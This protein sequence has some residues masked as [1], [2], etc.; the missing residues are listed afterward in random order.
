M[1]TR[2]PPPK[3]N[4]NP[5]WLPGSREFARAKKT[6]G[7]NPASPPGEGGT[8]KEGRTNSTVHSL[9]RDLGK[10]AEGREEVDKLLRAF[11]CK[12]D[13]R[14]PHVGGRE[15]IPGSKPVKEKNLS[16]VPGESELSERAG[17]G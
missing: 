5:R 12:L 7:Q 16:T 4:T 3:K 8:P 14:H 10:A 2:E 11:S 1:Q 9:V 15:K 13:H 6:E 17:T